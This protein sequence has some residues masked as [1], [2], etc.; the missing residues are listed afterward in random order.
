MA[1]ISVDSEQKVLENGRSDT[2]NGLSVSFWKKKNR[3]KVRKMFICDRVGTNLFDLRLA[4]DPSHPCGGG[5]IA[6]GTFLKRHS[7]LCHCQKVQELHLG[8]QL[9]CQVTHET[10]QHVTLRRYT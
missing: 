6:A 1:D 5:E 3:G 9:F 2:N 10:S 8:A 4:V 7:M